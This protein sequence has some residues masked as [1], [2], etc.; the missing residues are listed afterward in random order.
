MRKPVLLLIAITCLVIAVVMF[1][2]GCWAPDRSDQPTPTPA[3]TPQPAESA[4]PSPPTIQ[5][6]L[7]VSPE[8]NASTY[9]RDLFGDYDRPA[10]LSASLAEHGCYYSQ[11]DDMCYD[12]ASEVDVDHIVP[13][14]EAWRSGAHAWP[15]SQLDQFAGDTINLWL[16]TDN[17][18]QSKS[19]QDPATWLPPHPDITCFYIDAYVFV[20][21]SYHLTV[22]PAEAEAIEDTECM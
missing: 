15:E 13:L 18:N 8:Q 20:K 10:L 9:D 5:D 7:A 22:D 4:S 21:L 3:H 1:T 2:S 6:D 16:M 17:L 19:D 11:A 14:A 12:D